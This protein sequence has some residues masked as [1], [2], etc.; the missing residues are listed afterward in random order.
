[1]AAS[2]RPDDHGVRF[3]SAEHRRDSSAVSEDDLSHR[4]V[5]VRRLAARTLARIADERA[6]E[7]L[8]RSLADEDSE[9]AAWSAFGLGMVCQ[10]R[11]AEVVQRLVAR[12]A[13][14]SALSEPKTPESSHEPLAPDVWVAIVD[15]LA[16]CGTEEAE[17]TLRAW[18][19]HGT[20]LRA[21]QAALG[22][23]QLAARRGKLDDASL[24][25]LL[26][27]A[28]RDKD[29]VFDA[30]FAFS[31]LP[32]Q[33]DAVSRRLVEAATAA[34]A[35]R[36]RRRQLAVR[37]LGAA[38][39]EAADLLGRV[40]E[41]PLE[42]S[43][44]E[45]ADAARALGRLGE[46]GER[47]LLAALE[48]LTP[49]LTEKDPKEQEALLLSEEWAYIQ[50]LVA[51]PRA[52]APSVRVLFEHLA[53]LPRPAEADAPLARRLT[54]LRCRAASLL[55]GKASLSRQLLACDPNASG[56]A[57]LL[58]ELE[59]LDRGELTGA[60]QRRFSELLASMDPVVRHAALRLLPAHPEVSSAHAAL[61][62]ALGSENPGTVSVAGEL[63]AKYPHLAGADETPAPAVLEVGHAPAFK[64]HP[65][66]IHALL[67]ANKRLRDHDVEAKAAVMS[68]AAALQLLSLKP[69]LEEACRSDQPL[70]REHAERG[71]RLLGD[72]A[73]RCKSERPRSHQSEPS[74]AHEVKDVVLD[75]TTDIG[76]LR[77]TLSPRLA[78]LT[79]ARVV[80]LVRAGFYDG[81]VVH[82]AIAGFVVQFG[83]P[84][85]DGYGGAP[86][87]PLRSETSPVR[88]G[89]GSVGWAIAGRD[90]GSSQLFVTLGPHP[91][92]DGDYP[93]IGWAEPGWAR[94][95]AGDRILRIRVR[96]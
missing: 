10:H 48:R 14:L 94:L 58:A 52:A 69:V 62:K 16:R 11:E 12:S 15:A 81:I 20:P 8:R 61:A 85:G 47:H 84:D 37:A 22:L 82:R 46:A 33:S 87:P 45:R 38:G 59:V 36:D 39:S 51:L 50:T 77:L 89:S 43:P 13:S 75:V 63:I 57:G 21:E 79:V 31:R 5:A 2:D 74:T 42:F 70:L 78:P 1:M 34:F 64:P 53:S 19:L 67:G 83:D 73:R 49:S 93:L 24:V 72:A 96:S 68:A 60:R 6:F 44:A 7:L 95:S 26:E 29:A 18:L 80:E 76:D 41:H 32:K 92:L 35:A 65:D 9:V 90:T 4:A 71:L 86:K 28:T 55:A 30:L 66:L 88:F 3:L 17:R 27:V 23:G 54:S 56:R 25:A 40:L 91:H